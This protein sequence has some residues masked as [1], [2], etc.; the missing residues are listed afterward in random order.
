MSSQRLERV[1]VVEDDPDIQAI[2]CI[3]LRVFGRL[4]VGEAS[5]GEEALEK[6]RTFAPDLILLDVMMPGMDGPATL[7]GL[8]GNP[9]TAG[10]PIIFLTAKALPD[11]MDELRQLGALHVLVKP[12][13]P[14]ALS[15][16][17]DSV[18]RRYQGER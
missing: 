18:W 8:R 16:E 4:T 17:L 11:E 12:F 5:S 6:A 14:L 9:D 15:E 13:D 3:S 10:I 7:R 2:V 1:L